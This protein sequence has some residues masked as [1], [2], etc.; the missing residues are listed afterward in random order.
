MKYKTNAHIVHMI[1]YSRSHAS[2]NNKPCLISQIRRD[3]VYP[4]ATS[5][6]IVCQS[7]VG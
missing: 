7:E 6:R 2:T 3:E 4:G 1:Y 5:W